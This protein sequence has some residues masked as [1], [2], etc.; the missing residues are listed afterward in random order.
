M[1]TRDNVQTVI[2]G[3][4][5]GNILETFDRYYDDDVVMTENGVD[6]R[7]GKPTNREYEQAFVEGVEFHNAE[8]G[9]VIVD[10]DRAAVGWTLEFT[11][12][13]GTR[14]TQRQVAL[15]Q[16]REGRIVREDFYHA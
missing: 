2:D 6:T 3:I 4:L 7:V 13:G 8:V 9:T 16:W 12:R 15:Q 14:V 1:S 5:K 10:G 11:P